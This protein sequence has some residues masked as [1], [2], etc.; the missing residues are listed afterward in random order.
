MGMES[1]SN[2][3]MF[4]RQN[5]DYSLIVGVKERKR[6]KLRGIYFPVHVTSER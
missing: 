2:Y 1:R 5:W 4:R 6:K 3:K